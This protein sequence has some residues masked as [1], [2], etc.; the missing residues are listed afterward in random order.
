[1]VDLVGPDLQ[2]LAH[3][4]GLPTALATLHGN[5]VLYTCPVGQRQ[6][7]TYIAV[8]SAADRHGDD[9]MDPASPGTARLYRE[10]EGKRMLAVNDRAD[11]GPHPAAC[12]SESGNEVTIEELLRNGWWWDEYNRPVAFSYGLRWPSGWRYWGPPA[13]GMPSDWVEVPMAVDTRGTYDVRLAKAQQVWGAFQRVSVLYT[14]QQSV[15]QSS[16]L[17]LGDIS[18]SADHTRDRECLDRATP[19]TRGFYFSD[20]PDG[21]LDQLHCALVL[22]CH[23]DWTPPAGFDRSTWTPLRDV[24]PYSPLMNAIQDKGAQWVGGVVGGHLFAGDVQAVSR[25]FFSTAKGQVFSHDGRAFLPTLS[26][27]L[28][29]AVINRDSWDAQ[30]YPGYA[31]DGP[32]VPYALPWQHEAD[33]G[34]SAVAVRLAPSVPPDEDRLKALG[35]LES[36]QWIHGHLRV[37]AVVQHADAAQ[38]PLGGATASATVGGVEYAA[39]SDQDGWAVFEPAFS[40]ELNSYTVTVTP[41]PDQGLGAP[42]THYAI[43]LERTAGGPVKFVFMWDGSQPPP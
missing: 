32:F 18:I 33:P 41:P 35:Q 39:L 4:T 25:E 24:Q 7:G 1:M 8:L 40:A 2:P 30:T 36:P 34:E 43:G 38:T 17:N 26:D 22:C 3:V 15:P 10:H 12:F 31:D 28:W 11:E 37:R 5:N 6:F 13:E 16:A 14:N 9:P 19:I 23:D 21:A 29:L 42:L 20:L 27:A